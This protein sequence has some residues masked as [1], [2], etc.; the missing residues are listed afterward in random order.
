MSIER[1]L[2]HLRRLKSEQPVE[3]I[4]ETILAAVADFAEGLEQ[5]DDRTLVVVRCQ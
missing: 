2:S 3:M 1:L 5:S 4:G